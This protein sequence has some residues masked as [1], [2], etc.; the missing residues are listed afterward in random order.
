MGGMACRG[1]CMCGWK[2]SKNI[3]MTCRSGYLSTN[4]KWPQNI[5][6]SDV[7]T[8]GLQSSSG[9]NINREYRQNSEQ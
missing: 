5:S 6:N 2:M 3:G 1:L 9:Q 8:A 7:S 4:H